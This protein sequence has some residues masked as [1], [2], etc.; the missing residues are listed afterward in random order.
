[1]TTI[2][3]TWMIISTVIMNFGIKPAVRISMIFHTPDIATRFMDVI[4]ALYV[5]AYDLHHKQDN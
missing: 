1:M 3:A 4:F 5:F 2:C